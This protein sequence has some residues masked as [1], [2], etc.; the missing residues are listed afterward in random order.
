MAKPQNYFTLVNC[1]FTH[2]ANII[3][4]SDAILEK[5]Y[6]DFQRY[7]HISLRHLTSPCQAHKML[8]DHFPPAVAETLSSTCTKDLTT[9]L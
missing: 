5:L 8:M 9:N 6:I 4:Q 2:N 1:S 3:T 7:F